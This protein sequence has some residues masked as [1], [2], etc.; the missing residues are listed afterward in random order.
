[1]KLDLIF[2]KQ[3][4]VFQKKVNDFVID[5]TINQLHFDSEMHETLFYYRFGDSHPIRGG[6][7]GT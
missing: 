1:M 5:V 7:N 4:T 6:A 2:M 3:Y